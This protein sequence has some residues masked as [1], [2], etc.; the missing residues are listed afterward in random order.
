M[1]IRRAE[2]G[3]LLCRRAAAH[4][5]RAGGDQ[6]DVVAR[7]ADVEVPGVTVAYDRP[8]DWAGELARAM[9]RETEIHGGCAG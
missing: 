1:L 4:S 8:A 6:P 7:G 3:C 2:I 5:R 9:A